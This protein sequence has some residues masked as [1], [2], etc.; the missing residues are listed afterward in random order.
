[1]ASP[2][3]NKLAEAAAALAIVEDDDE[4]E[5]LCDLCC[6]KPREVRF[7]KCHHSITCHTC[8]LQLLS[9]TENRRLK[10]PNCNDIV[11]SI[12]FAEAAEAGSV[13]PLKELMEPAQQLE[14]ALGSDADEETPTRPR[15]GSG[16]RLTVGRQPS[17][18][19]LSTT[20]QAS[21]SKPASREPSGGAPPKPLSPARMKT[22]DS[23]GDDDA[24]CTP[25][26]KYIALHL[27]KQTPHAKDAAVAWSKAPS[28]CD[29]A[30]SGDLG[31]MRQLLDGGGADLN[32]IDE[33]GDLPLHVATSHGHLEMMR[34]LLDRGADP[35]LPDISNDRPLH[36]VHQGESEEAEVAAATLLLSRGADANVSNDRRETPMHEAVTS[37]LALTKLLFEAG[38]S[39]IELDEGGYSPL[40]NACADG[41]LEICKWLYANG[42]AGRAGQQRTQRQQFPSSHPKQLLVVADNELIETAQ[43]ADHGGG[44][45]FLVACHRGHE[46]VAEWLL[47]VGANA[48]ARDAEDSTALHNAAYCGHESLVAWLLDE[49]GGFALDDADEDGHTPLH[50]AC[51]RGHAD[52]VESLMERGAKDHVVPAS[53]ELAAHCACS[54]LADDVAD[55]DVIDVLV[56]L[57]AR[58]CAL[59]SPNTAKETPIMLCCRAGRLRLVQWL[60]TQGASLRST[61]KHG[62]SMLHEAVMRSA[63]SDSD[64]EDGGDSDSDDDDNSEDED[65]NDDDSEGSDA[66]EA[67]GARVSRY[68][69]LVEWLCSQTDVDT[70]ARDC[71]G[72]LATDMVAPGLVSSRITPLLLAAQ[73][74]VPVE[75]AASG[76]AA[77][78]AAAAPAEAQ[79]SDA[80]MI[81]ARCGRCE[82]LL[83]RYTRCASD[84]TCNVCRKSCG[85]N[86][87]F[88]VVYHCEDGAEGCTFDMCGKCHDKAVAG[89]S[90]VPPHLN[91]SSEQSRFE[92]ARTAR[93]NARLEART[94]TRAE[95]QLQAYAHRAAAVVLTAEQ[96]IRAAAAAGLDGG[97]SLNAEARAE[98]SVEAASQS[99]EV[100]VGP[101]TERSDDG[102]AAEEPPPRPSSGRRGQRGRRR[103]GPPAADVTAD[104]GY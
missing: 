41:Q 58:G 96:A 78:A 18:A 42:G 40:M 81:G 23:A 52:L 30:A 77:A 5:T 70:G 39:L 28:L 71:T 50:M 88:G 87:G 19:R 89:A 102:V 63:G 14:R 92:A 31:Q 64:S 6:D 72:A 48:H 60:H 80:A 17:G 74:P 10:C 55:D 65:F 8:T 98:A 12:S 20:R 91:P 67:D 34:E 2:D 75:P 76:T 21:G 36:L 43:C 86:S 69:E 4:E 83:R 54:D 35:N 32:E 93:A 15:Q 9:R 3:P 56:R 61:T 7:L 84:Y 85:G 62:R 94:E 99:D 66:D 47:S 11:E 53:G 104:F 1:M 29:A 68:A 24:S 33:N 26:D 103:G 57:Q 95:L 90:G 79:P 44:T 25:L 22:Y 27:Q 49:V 13:P 51:Q 38:A 37:S 101:T 97:E 59:D 16:A 82:G 45:P 73:K 46:D 100:S